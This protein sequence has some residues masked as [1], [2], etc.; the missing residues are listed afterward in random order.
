MFPTSKRRQFAFLLN[1][2][3]TLLGSAIGIYLKIVGQNPSWPVVGSL[4]GA[5]IVCAVASSFYTHLRPLPDPAGN[6]KLLLDFIGNRILEFGTTNGVVLRL[7]ILLVYRPA[8]CFYLRKKFKV[9]WNL[10]MANMKDVDI[11]F[12]IKKGVAGEALRTGEPTLVNMQEAQGDWGFT[13]KELAKFPKH[14]MIWSYPIFKLDPKEEPTS[15]IIGTVN[16]DSTQVG[17]FQ[18]VVKD[19]DEYDRRMEELRDI[20]SRVTF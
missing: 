12:D 4:T 13:E 1:P 11:E 14:T 19:A 3:V 8:S 18:I 7:N 17:A 2:S 15:K 16:L 9:R 10:R 5:L 6:I 20:V